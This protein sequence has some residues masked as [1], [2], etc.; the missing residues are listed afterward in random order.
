MRRL[1]PEERIALVEVGEPG[2]GPVSD[3]TFAECI[4][5]GWGCWVREPGWRGWLGGK[6]WHV[7]AEGRRAKELDDLALELDRG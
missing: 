4:R 3:A 5:M 6:V 2:E 1:T 7:T